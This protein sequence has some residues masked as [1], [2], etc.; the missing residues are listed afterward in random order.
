[1]EQI[2]VVKE[3]EDG[4]ALLVMERHQSCNKC[5]ACMIGGAPHLEL[6]LSN[7][8]KAEVGDRVVIYI[9]EGRLLRLAFMV[10][11]LPLLFFLAGYILGTKV[12]PRPAHGEAGSIAT[13][14]LS[15][16]AFYCWIYF[17]DRRFGRKAQ[18]QPE[19]VRI[20]SEHREDG[21]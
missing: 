12:W 19:I 5:G 20:I 15:A 21:I 2:G 7:K 17:F 13:G 16:A 18:N 6:W 8:I 14:I 11:I 3:L 10:Y 9:P 1:M 4:M